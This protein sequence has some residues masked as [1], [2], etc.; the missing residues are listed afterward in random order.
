MMNIPAP[1]DLPTLCGARVKL[2]PPVERFPFAHW[3]DI[4][5]RDGF[6]VRRA[7][8]AVEYVLPGRPD[9]RRIR[10]RARRNRE[11]GGQCVARVHTGIE[12]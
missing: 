2:R 9:L 4:G 5:Q 6:N 10:E 1:Q 8:S 11:P 12:G 3:D 7:A